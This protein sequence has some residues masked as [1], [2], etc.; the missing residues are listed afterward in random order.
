[1]HV[2]VAGTRH[3]RDVVDRLAV[4][5]GERVFAILQVRVH[6]Y[7]HVRHEGPR[8]RRPDDEL[9]RDVAFSAEES[10]RDVDRVGLHGLVPLRHFMRRERRAAARAV[11]QHFVPAIQQ[12]LFVQPLE[13]PPHGLD[14]VIAVGDVWAFVVEPIGDAVRQRFPIGLVLEHAFA[15][16]LV[17]PLD[18]VRFDLALAVDLER[19]LDLDL[20]GQPVRVPPRDARDRLPQHRVK[21]TDQILERPR[22][23]V[24]D[25]GPAIRG[26]RSLKEDERRTVARGVADAGEQPLVFPR[27]E[28]MFFQLVDRLG[29]VGRRIRHQVRR[30]STPRTTAA[31]F[32]SAPRAT[33]MICSTDVG[34]RASGRQL[35]VMIDKPSTRMP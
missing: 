12:R 28:Q 2:H 4:L 14:V 35:S 16:E 17:E 9:A 8:R 7:R 19:L 30:S 21:A 24:V 3:G 20:D 18:A 34:S 1:M 33:A 15:A 29:Q 22:E 25:A 11:R 27:R 31:S 6:G 13:Q 23:D 5:I 32:G 10:E 26:R